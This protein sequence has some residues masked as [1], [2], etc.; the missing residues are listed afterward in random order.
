MLQLFA[1]AYANVSAL[2]RSTRYPQLIL[3]VAKLSQPN[4]KNNSRVY[5]SH[6]VK[7]VSPSRENGRD[8]E[9]EHESDRNEAGVGISKDSNVLK[10]S[11]S[12]EQF[13]VKRA[14]H[15]LCLDVR[16]RR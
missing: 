8:V 11:G 15:S 9:T 13:S 12:I 1:P 16:T 14:T 4:L 7:D 2:D 5:P 3:S 6:V 10:E